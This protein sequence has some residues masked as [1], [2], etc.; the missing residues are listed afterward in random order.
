MGRSDPHC[1]AQTASP[2]AAVLSLE[3]YHVGAFVLDITGAVPEGSQ[4]PD[5]FG[6]AGVEERGQGTRGVPWN[7]RD[8]VVSILQSGSGTGSRTPWPPAAR[9]DRWERT[10]THGMVSP[11]EGN[12]ARRDGRPG[13]R[14]TSSY[15]RGGGNGPSRTPR[16][17]GGAASRA[18]GL[19]RLIRPGRSLR[20]IQPHQHV[21]VVVQDREAPDGDGED[22]GQFPQAVF[23][24]L[25]AI[26]RSLGEEEGTSDTAGDAVIPTRHGRINK[27]CTGDRHA[28]APRVI[29]R[30]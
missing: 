29:S 12:R 28:A 23:E 20:G 11:S 8:P 30:A 18:H 26:E 7:L 5:L 24:P 25:F 15:R 6:P 19:D 3:I 2:K 10:A 16:R 27:V 17:E 4:W 1:E 22:L 9:P 14:S 21:Q 13:S